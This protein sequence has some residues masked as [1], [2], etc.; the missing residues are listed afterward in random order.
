MFSLSFL[1]V[2]AAAAT[3]APAVI[4]TPKPLTLPSGNLFAPVTFGD[5]HPF[6]LSTVRNLFI[7]ASIALIVL[8]SVQTTKTEGL[9]GTIGGRAESAYRGRLGLSEQLAR[10][11]NFIASSFIILA[12]IYF[13]ITK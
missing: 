2:I 1:W 3:A 7:L 8:M 13:F 11:T 9:S 4:P 12:I 6:F 10:M 5:E